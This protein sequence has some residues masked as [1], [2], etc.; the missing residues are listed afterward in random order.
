MEES[1]YTLSNR[2]LNSVVKLEVTKAELE[3]NSPN[4]TVRGKLQNRVKA[5][6]IFHLSHSLGMNISLKDAEKIAEG[7]KLED[8]SEKLYVLNNFRNVLE[9]NRATVTEAPSAVDFNLLMH[10]NKIV[11][12]DWRETWDAR[13][14]GEGEMADSALDN[15][16]DLRDTELTEQQIEPAL[17]ELFDWFAANQTRLNGIILIGILLYRLI[18]IMPFA[19]GNKLTILALSDHLLHKFGYA[20]K[21][22]LPVLRNFDVHEQEY[23]E[24]WQYAKRNLDLTLWL[25]RFAGNLAKD[26]QENKA[27]VDTF[28][29]EEEKTSKQPF[30][31]LNKRQLKILRYLQTIPTVKRE[32]YCQM[33]EVS[34]MTAFR[35]LNDLV[36]KKLIK[37][38]GQGRGTKYL[39][40]TR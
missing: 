40:A 14:R 21:T 27:E 11:L 39:L 36:R 31:D 9:F 26:V 24:A 30:L 29:A 37:L 8:K 4:Y 23:Y 17:R 1:K 3:H 2:L 12:T 38:E 6:N 33:M 15:W 16:L 5:L 10:L 35:D 13:F 34:T 22:F 25:E 20:D 19:S 28:L 18:E 7:R 32:E